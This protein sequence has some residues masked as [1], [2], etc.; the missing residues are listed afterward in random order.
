MDHPFSEFVITQP[1][2]V[3]AWNN[4]PSPEV[5]E[6]YGRNAQHDERYDGQ[7]E[8]SNVEQKHEEGNPPPIVS[9]VPAADDE[10]HEGIEVDEEGS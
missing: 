10:E 5:E 4:H 2:S 3:D 6:E 8:D 1:T 9:L 7:D